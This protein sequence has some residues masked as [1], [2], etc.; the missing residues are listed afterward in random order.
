MD[1]Y[2]SIA[3]VAILILR[4]CFAKLPKRITGLFWIV[5][6][7]RLL[8]PV[9]FDMAFSLLNIAGLGRKT[10]EPAFLR[11][12]VNAI[13][14]DPVTLTP[15]Q[16]IA[17]NNTVVHSAAFDWKTV[18]FCV[19]LM[20]MAVILTY[21]AI[22]TVRMCSMLK[23][24]KRPAGKDYYVSDVIDTSFVLGIIRPRVYMQSGLSEQEKEYIYLHELT[25]IRNMDHITRFIGVLTVCLHWFNP[26]V[27]LGFIRMCSDLEMRCDE[28]VI[29][30]MGDWIRKDY[31]MSIVEHARERENNRVGL[32]A[33][34]AGDNRN[35]KE[36]KMRV[37]NLIKY[38]KVSKILAGAVIVFAVGSVTVLSSKAAERKNNEEDVPTVEI[39]TV[40]DT[41]AGQEAAQGEV[42]TDITV[43]PNT[44]DFPEQEHVGYPVGD[45]NVTDLNLTVEESLLNYGYNGMEIPD[46]V[47]YSDEGRPYSMSYD[48]RTNPTLR[49][50]AEQFEK[51]GYVVEA[52]VFEYLDKE[53]NVKTGKELYHFAASKGEVDAVNVNLCSKEYGEESFNEY[54]EVDGLRYVENEGDDW[55]MY[56]IWD[57]KTGVIIDAAGDEKFDWRSMGLFEA[58][59]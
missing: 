57:M 27:W 46:D 54:E 4:R 52:P 48:Y 31:C 41:A 30:R 38:K 23:D 25:H 33:A 11:P 47:E 56:R 14:A 45:P 18:V 8:C 55:N 26:L 22:K 6:G 28:V 36:I 34:F 59:R 5:A 39:Q 3:I 50:L 58:I 32:Y 51:N 17:V 29:D 13:Y 42:E 21:L 1:I 53:G 19:W 43:G 37:N 9:N 2:G 16:T 24:A 35:G 7:V 40:E 44:E 20:G 49:K 10:S 12:A 15:H